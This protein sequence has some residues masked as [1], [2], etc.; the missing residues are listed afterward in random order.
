MKNVILISVLFTYLLL[1]GCSTVYDKQVEWQRIKPESFPVL[2]AI[3]YA[4]ISLQKSDNDTQKM[5]MAITASKMAA[6]VE[7]AEQ[8][9]GQQISQDLTM[10][11]LLLMDQTMSS[12][13]QG[14]IRGAKVFKS[15]PVGDTY[16]TELTL[17]F[18]DVYDIYEVM[19]VNKEIKKVNYY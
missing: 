15:Y 10:A 3:G 18:K 2:H 5:L 1:S 11:D 16:A 14:V 7:L 13:V 8:V 9:H 4:P 12:K 19:N 17:D 6:Y